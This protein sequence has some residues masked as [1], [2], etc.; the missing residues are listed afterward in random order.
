[1]HRL[2]TLVLTIRLSPKVGRALVLI[3]RDITPPPSALLKPINFLGR[4]A[5]FTVDQNLSFLQLL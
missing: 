1:M 4:A 2:S 3:W 5:L